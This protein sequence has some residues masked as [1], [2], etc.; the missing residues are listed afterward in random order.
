MEKKSFSVRGPSFWQVWLSGK[1]THTSSIKLELIKI[2]REANKH[3]RNA[4][5]RAKMFLTRDL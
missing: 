2:A 5:Q 3:I 1:H 4:Q